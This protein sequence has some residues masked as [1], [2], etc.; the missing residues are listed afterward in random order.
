MNTYGD[1]LKIFALD[2][3]KALIPGGTKGL[4]REMAVCLLEN[5]CDVSVASRNPTG[6]EDIFEY[7]EKLNRQ[8]FQ[9]KCDVTKTNEVIEMVN[10]AKQNM[11]RI[12]ILINSM[13]TNNPTMLTEMDDDTWDSIV[14]LNLRATFIMIREVAKIMKEQKYGKIINISSMKSILGVSDAG[15]SAYC[16]SKGGVNMLTKQTACE[17][18]AYNITVNAIAPTFIKTSIN[19]AMLDNIEFKKS[20]EQRIPMGRIG[21][22]QDLMGLTLLL[23]SDASS[24]I[25][26]QILLLDGGIAAR[27]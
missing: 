2:G 6:N 1:A 11:G 23:A 18:A 9:F 16:A 17:L 10:A 21:T 3:K 4:G 25:T 22:F 7:A 19:G 27:Q 14:N 8:Y 24:F 5:G 13:G 15:Y 26:G 20:L 12:D